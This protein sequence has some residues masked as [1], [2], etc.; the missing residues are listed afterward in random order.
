MHIRSRV[1]VCVFVLWRCTDEEEKEGQADA[2][3]KKNLFRRGLLWLCESD[4]NTAAHLIIQ[5]GRPLHCGVRCQKWG[6]EYR[7]GKAGK[8]NGTDWVKPRG[9][10]RCLYTLITA[11][12]SAQSEAV[13]GALIGD[14][15]GPTSKGG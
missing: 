10:L 3:R 2:P 13:N 5:L 8:M 1:Y 9:L 6:R 12:I 7:G 11:A 15:G 4:R 14:P